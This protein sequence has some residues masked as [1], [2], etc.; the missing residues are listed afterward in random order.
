MHL[1]LYKMLSKASVQSAQVVLLQS[2]TK[3]VESRCL[4][5]RVAL[6]LASPGRNAPSATRLCPSG[7]N[8]Q[9]VGQ[10]LL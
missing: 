9:V 10:T 3:V 4:A 2:G 6:G 5:L 7:L 8:V 1:N